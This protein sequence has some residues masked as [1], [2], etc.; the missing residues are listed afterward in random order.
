MARDVAKDK[1]VQIIFGSSENHDQHEEKHECCPNEVVHDWS[2]QED[3]NVNKECCSQATNNC[4]STH[5][6]PHKTENCGC[7][8]N[9]NRNGPILSPEEIYK[10][11]LNL[12][13]IRAF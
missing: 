5:H 3:Y 9:K 13:L 2:K 8:G 1:G 7:C 4:T 11:L 12:L 6:E 10:V